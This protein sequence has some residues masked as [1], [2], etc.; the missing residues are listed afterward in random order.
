MRYRI[1]FLWLTF[2]SASSLSGQPILYKDSVLVS[3]KI[4]SRDSSRNIQYSDWKKFSSHTI[5]MLDGFK[6]ADAEKQSRYGGYQSVKYNATGYFRTEKNQHRWM[7]IDPDG[8][9]FIVAA[10]NGIRQG[11]SPDNEA[12]FQLKFGGS[13]EKWIST[14]IRT[15]RKLGFNTAG[16]WSDVDAITNY[17]KTSDTP[18]A[19]TTQLSL[20]GGYMKVAVKNNP[21]RKGQ[22]A[23]AF[24]LDDDF[25]VYCDTACKKLVSLSNDANLLG[26]FSDNEIAFMQTEFKEI[27]ALSDKANKCYIAAIELM[28]RNQ[29]DA[30]TVTKD[31]KE[32][33]MGWIAGKYFETVS[34]YIRRYDPNHLIIGSRLHS[35]AKNNHY[36]I[37]AAAPYVDVNSINYYGYWQPQNNHIADWSKWSDKPFFITEFYTKG[38]DADMANISGAGWL[39][40]S[41]SDRGIHYQNFCLELL[42]AKNCVGWHWFRYQDNDP[43]DP[44]ADPSNKDANKGLVTKHY[45][46][47]E[48]MAVW[49][50]QLNNNKYR[51]SKYFDSL[52]K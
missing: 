6:S 11:K 48:K 32:Q 50:E 49:M 44:S 45:E 29:V 25:S 10:I 28:K 38:E 14:E 1:V 20:L 2:L 22:P 33:L 21:S 3:A 51:I 26:H 34:K 19:Y 23:V 30:T 13:V 46:V 12:S 31:Q 47:Y 41:Q 35:S 4:W 52:V 15:A 5:D 27:I 36:I 17:N 24:I 42:K 43:N 40:K 7:I 9:E 16:S 39:V 8:Y 18:F 37:E